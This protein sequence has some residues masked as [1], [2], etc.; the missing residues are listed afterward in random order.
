M[1][2]L[3]LG[4]AHV[5]LFHRVMTCAEFKGAAGLLLKS[6]VETP[7]PRCYMAIGFGH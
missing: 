1:G 2:Q 7:R 5:F 3:G 6:N 4:V